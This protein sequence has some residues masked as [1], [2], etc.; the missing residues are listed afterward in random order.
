MQALLLPHTTPA[1]LKGLLG[2]EEAVP[3]HTAASA[4][5]PVDDLHVHQRAAVQAHEGTFSVTAGPVRLP[6]E[7]QRLLPCQTEGCLAGSC[8]GRH[9]WFPTCNG[10]ATRTLTVPCHTM[11]WCSAVDIDSGMPCCGAAAVL[12]SPSTCLPRTGTRVW[13][14]LATVLS[15]H[16]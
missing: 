3:V 14:Y 6:R 1:G 10:I 4:Q 9:F 16:S 2:Q 11:L 7:Q 8:C 13:E 5:G 15:P 12:V